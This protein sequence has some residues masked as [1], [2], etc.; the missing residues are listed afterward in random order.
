MATFTQQSSLATVSPM[1]VMKPTSS[2]F[3]MIYLP[4]SDTFQNTTF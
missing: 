3:T 2:P 4:L 1:P